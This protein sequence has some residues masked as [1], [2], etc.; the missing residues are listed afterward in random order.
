M[1][2]HRDVLSRDVERAVDEVWAR[3]KNHGGAHRDESGCRGDTKVIGDPTKN[4]R[5][6]GSRKRLARHGNA[7]G[8][9]PSPH[10]TANTRCQRDQQ[11]R[12]RAAGAVDESETPRT[13]DT[14]EDEK[15]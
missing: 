14:G 1:P 11:V 7:V 5:E 8:P 3:H 4:P 6:H 10:T 12:Q 13:G 15:P 2:P 9:E